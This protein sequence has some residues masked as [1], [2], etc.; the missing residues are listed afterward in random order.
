M[1]GWLGDREESGA[2]RGGNGGPGSSVS[3][4]SRGD[5]EAL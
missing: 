3:R 2:R 4:A 1:V 5:K